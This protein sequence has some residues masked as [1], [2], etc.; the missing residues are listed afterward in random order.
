MNSLDIIAI[1]IAIVSVV[2]AFLALR[3]SSRAGSQILNCP[4]EYPVSGENKRA[5]WGSLRLGA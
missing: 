3:Q 1:V 4:H 2:I 5:Y